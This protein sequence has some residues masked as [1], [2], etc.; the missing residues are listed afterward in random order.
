MLR[1]C[2][3]SPGNKVLYLT[4]RYFLKKMTVHFVRHWRASSIL[5]IIIGS[6]HVYQWRILIPVFFKASLKFHHACSLSTEFVEVDIWWKPPQ[7]HLL[8]FPLSSPAWVLSTGCKVA[9]QGTWHVVGGD[10]TI[11]FFLFALS[12]FS[13]KTLNRLPW[14][15]WFQLVP[16][17]IQRSVSLVT[18]ITSP[19]LGDSFKI[20]LCLM[21]RVTI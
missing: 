9:H 8:P 15:C 1:A 14:F 17:K 13:S 12:H 21:I 16:L 3:D 5:Y 10:F 2:I 4:T 18:E 7:S 6:S 19:C 20:S 11:S